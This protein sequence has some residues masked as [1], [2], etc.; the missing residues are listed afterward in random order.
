MISNEI[1][2]FVAIFHSDE[3]VDHEGGFWTSLDLNATD[4]KTDW[5]TPVDVSVMLERYSDF[6]P[7]VLAVLR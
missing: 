4:I 2:N 6:H 5:Q 1:H 3:Q 7:S